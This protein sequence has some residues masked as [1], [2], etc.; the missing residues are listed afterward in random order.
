VG[1]EL[2][3]DDYLPKPFEPRELVARIQ[4]ILRRSRADVKMFSSNKGRPKTRFSKWFYNN[5]KEGTDK[6]I[7]LSPSC[8]I[9][10]SLLFSILFSVK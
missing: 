10:P 6:K 4:S 9:I 3:A 7:C 5:S 8:I 2:G 1:L